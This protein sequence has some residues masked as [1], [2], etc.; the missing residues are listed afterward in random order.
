[1]DPA[2]GLPPGE[3]RA[4][5]QDKARRALDILARLLPR[6]K[7]RQGEKIERI[8]ILLQWGIGDAVLALPL[9]RALRQTYPDARITLV[10][11]PWLGE[12][13]AGED[14]HDDVLRLEPPW[15][16][17]Q[18]KYRVWQ[19][20]WRRFAAELRRVRAVN[21]DLLIAPRFDAREIAQLRLLR[22]DRTAAFRAAGGA[23][24]ISHDIGLTRSEHD[25][26]HRSEVAALAARRITGR[27]VASVPR[28]RAEPA[29][30]DAMRARLAAAPHR[31]GLTL[32][33]HNG[34][35]SPL[36]RW[37]WDRTGE[38]LRSVPSAFGR[39]VL[40]DDG[41]GVPSE[42]IK[43]PDGIPTLTIRCG[44][45]DAKA[46]LSLCD[47]LL[48]SD[49]GI[50]HV[51]A[52]VGCPVLTVFGPTSPLWFGPAGPGHEVVLAEPMACRPCHDRCIY[53][54]PLCMAE[55]SVHAVS[56][57][58]HRMAAAL[59]EPTRARATLRAVGGREPNLA[60][61]SDRQR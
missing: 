5:R 4:R 49:N 17:Y 52:A 22:A 24:W 54:A 46:L 34:A 45:E 29:R 43:V 11:K 33:V 1:M 53:G 26:L 2:I 28:M 7:R 37:G 12:L 47:A 27:H 58:L 38:V 3:R 18:G 20:E 39:I 44:L 23:G 32:A 56:G 36:R 19:P 40:L 50:M 25:S 13:F 14:V 51:A 42:A 60:A 41:N 10:G 15:T 8:G 31:S 61:G 9:L 55:V 30:L 48:C 59:A 35:G 16:R 21:Y 57:A 6:R